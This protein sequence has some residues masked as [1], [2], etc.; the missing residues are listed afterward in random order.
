MKNRGPFMIHLAVTHNFIF[1]IFY[2]IIFM[3]G[4][5]L[6]YAI[7]IYYTLLEIFVAIDYSF[8]ELLLRL[9][10]MKHDRDYDI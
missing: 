4:G 9:A 6:I 3:L 5:K 10:Y 2:A 7:G 1:Y 8:V